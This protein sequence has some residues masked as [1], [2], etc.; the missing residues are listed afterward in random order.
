MA[1][2]RRIFFHHLQPLLRFRRAV[3][4]LYLLLA[5]AGLILTTQMPMVGAHPPK[6]HH[7][8]LQQITQA[9][10]ASDPVEQGKQL[11]EAG[12]YTEAIADL[13]QGLE[14]YQQQG[15]Q[16]RQAMVLS[17]LSLTYQQLGNWPDATQ[18]VTKSLKLLQIVP[19]SRLAGDQAQVLAQS[20]DIQGRLL[21][22]TGKPEDALDSWSKSLAIY[23]Q[24]KDSI[25]ILR[26]QINQARAFQ[27]LGMQQRALT[28][29]TQLQAT[30]KTQPDSTVKA[31]GLR[32]LGEVLQFVG[33]TESAQA[34]L[35]QSLDVAQ[36]ISSSTDIG[37]ALLSLGNQA[38]F[39]E[40]LPEALKYYR[41]AAS[42]RATSRLQAQLN[43]LSTL[44]QLN[45]TSEAQSLW[46]QIQTQVAQ[47]PPSR[48]GVYARINLAQSL[49]Q[50]NHFRDQ[51]QQNDSSVL[52]PTPILLAAQTTLD[53]AIAHA[54]TLGD[55]RAQAEAL[56]SLG[57]W[58]VLNNQAKKAQGL[59]QQ[60]ILQ[61]QSLNTP[62]I[63][64]RLQWRLGHL[65]QQQGNLTGAIAAYRVAVQELQNLRTDLTTVDNTIQF[66]FRKSVEPV[67][68]EYVDLLLTEKTPSQENLKAARA[69][70][71]SL[72]T[73][74]IANFLQVSCLDTNKVSIDAVT[75]KEDPTAAFIYSI[76]LPNRMAII[77]KLPRRSELQYF[78]TTSDQPLQFKDQFETRVKRFRQAL[79]QRTSQEV[80]V[81]A[82]WLYNKLI[83]PEESVIANSG[84]KTLVFVLDGNLRNIPIA[85]LHDGKRF[86]IKQSYNIALLP[87]LQLFEPQRQQ[88]R[89]L[90]VIAAGLSESPS[91]EFSP[92]PFVTTELAQIQAQVP[93]VELLNQAFTRQAFTEKVNALPFP[94]VHL[95]THGKFAS[96]VD[97]TFILAWNDRITLNQLST[98]LKISNLRRTV[99]IELL[100]LSACQTVVGDQ[101]AAL[102]LAGVAVRAG[103]RSTLATLWQIDDQATSLLVGQFY[104]ELAKPNGY[105][106][107]ALSKAQRFLA[108]QPEYQHPY[109]WAPFVLVG[110]WM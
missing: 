68:R 95:A 74:E 9:S 16:L 51:D 93:S 61:S 19:N 24:L 75:D 64:Y 1:R 33:E 3:W 17:N 79:G 56:G 59:L 39:R 11:Y 22:A 73:A 35:K 44:I 66:S 72:Q 91:P 97:E 82:Q 50:L 96:K 15:D 10:L 13:Q 92:L 47:L 55:I 23:T 110:N 102:G 84:V 53:E 65:L 99:P 88:Q 27:V 29:L 98:M 83:R 106:A 5:L 38:R 80:Y 25:G 7:P 62:E 18:A 32:S 60:A 48:A 86:F 14:H 37:A 42:S 34:M 45:E 85:A 30:I 41:Q 89:K 101:Q 100:V 52:P 70:I 67:Y 108:E 94:V 81:N 2:K 109:Y 36:R 8:A 43:Q 46:S 71:D 12:R 103:A 104:Q 57:E 69:A 58:Y 63:S 40:Q 76:L 28:T 20:F 77:L 54:Q 31:V 49:M 26:S 78:S 6:P 105:K 87:G 21:L 4:L 90:K 107:E